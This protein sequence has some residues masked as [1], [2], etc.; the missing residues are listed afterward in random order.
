[1]SEREEISRGLCAG[2]SYRAIA[3]LLGRAVSRISCEVSDKSGRDVTGQSLRRNGHLTA[4]G[5]RS[6]ACLPAGPR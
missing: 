1:M 3:G 2:E 4:P 6:S 5:G